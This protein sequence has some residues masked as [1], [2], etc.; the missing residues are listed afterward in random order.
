[1]PEAKGQ[2]IVLTLIA[3]LAQ[4]AAF[5][6][7]VTEELVGHISITSPR[8]A[9]KSVVVGQPLV[10]E[11]SIAG[12]LTLEQYNIVLLQG[13]GSSAI[14]RLVQAGP[15]LIDQTT[16]A[17]EHMGM[18]ELLVSMKAMAIK[19]TQIVPPITF[20][21]AGAG[22]LPPLDVKT[23]A[24]A[25]EITSSSKST[26]G[27]QRKLFWRLHDVGGYR[28]LLILGL[29]AGFFALIAFSRFF[30]TALKKLIRRLRK[31]LPPHLRALR[32]RLKV[33]QA[34]EDPKAYAFATTALL[35]DMLEIFER[36]P[37]HDK[38]DNEIVDRLRRHSRS[39][40]LAKRVQAILAESEEIRYSN[41]QFHEALRGQWGQ[42]LTEIYKI[43]EKEYE[44]SLVEKP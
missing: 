7:A 13:A 5:G 21:A 42:S 1:L 32:D 41:G 8:P 11:V 6:A 19:E 4:S 24:M 36:E 10:L 23:S 39:A 40:H 12:P 25:L 2:K 30:F 35:R 28:Y 37:V 31:R 38:A 18:N 27:F 3:L 17:V 14:N 33:V 29:I 22:L 43:L 15:L 16:I 20:T 34:V 26:P 9:P 44:D